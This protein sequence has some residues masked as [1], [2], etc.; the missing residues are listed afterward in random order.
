MR[1]IVMALLMITLTGSLMSAGMTMYKPGAKNWINSEHYFTYQFSKKPQIGLV[2][3][4]IKISDKAGARLTNY[5]ILAVSGMPSMGNAHDSP[6]ILFALN[7]KGDYLFPVNIVMLGTWQV[8][9]KIIK[10]KKV[11]SSGVVSFDVK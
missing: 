2:I 4:K 7:K 10:D 3:V 11:I 9:I 1:K 8:N 6:E 5:S